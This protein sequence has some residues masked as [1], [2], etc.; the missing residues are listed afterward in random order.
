MSGLGGATHMLAAA[1]CGCHANLVWSTVR[2]VS[3]GCF[4]LEPLVGVVAVVY[5][6]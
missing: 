3:V 1:F 5:A 2:G 4:A 6:A